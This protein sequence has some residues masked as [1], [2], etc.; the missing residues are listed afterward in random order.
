M[1][2]LMEGLQRLRAEVAAQYAAARERL[3]ARMIEG[4]WV[5]E[6]LV[7]E[8]GLMPLARKH[9]IGRDQEI[10]LMRI[11]PPYAKDQAK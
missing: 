3:R 11:Y 5:A 8:L 6:R 10:G 4:E 7:E 1:S 2:G 9:V